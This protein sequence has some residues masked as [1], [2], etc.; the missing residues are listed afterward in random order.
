MIHY[1]IRWADSKLD[2]EVF[3]TEEQARASAEALKRPGENYGIEKADGDCQQCNRIKA[4]Y[5]RATER[6]TGAT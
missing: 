2:W 5:L 3:Q 6:N 4:G 1:H